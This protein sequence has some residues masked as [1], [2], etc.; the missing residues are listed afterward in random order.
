MKLYEID[1]CVLGTVWELDVNCPLSWRGSGVY[2]VDYAVYR[3]FRQK[4]SA[5]SLDRALKLVSEWWKKNDPGWC[6]L[7]AVYYDPSTVEEK[8][9]LDDGTVEE[10]YETDSDYDEPVFSDDAPERYSIEVEL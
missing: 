3:E 7:D 1:V 10:V 6:S 4:V 8:E 9:D 5:T 2:D